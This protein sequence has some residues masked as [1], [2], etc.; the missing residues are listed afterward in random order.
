MMRPADKNKSP[1]FPANMT[2]IGKAWRQSVVYA[3]GTFL[4]GVGQIALAPLLTR[5]LSVAE[6]GSYEVLLVTYFVLKTLLVIPLSSALVY[7]QC[8]CCGTPEERKDLLSTVSLISAM[9]AA[10]F[11]LCGILA[12]RW[13]SL[14]V[15][16]GSAASA[17]GAII[18]L[19][20]ALDVFVQL[21]LGAFRAAEQPFHYGVAALIQLTGTLL[22]S[23]AFVGRFS[24]G[25]RGVF[26]AMAASNLFADIFI[27]VALALG[28]R[29]S[30]RLDW[31]R[32][33]PVL[34]FAL[35]LVPMHA[36]NLVSSVS[37]RYFLRSY[38]DLRTVGVYALSYRIG[39]GISTLVVL[40]FLTAW[41]ALI[42]AEKD[43][44][45]IGGYVGKAASNLWMAGM[46]FVAVG[47]AAARP[48]LLF[49]GGGK[50]KFLPAA[51]IVPIV[52]LGALL[53]GVMQ[54]FLSLAVARGRI[55]L[56]MKVLVAAAAAALVFNALLIPAYGMYGAALATVLSYGTGAALAY[57]NVSRLGPARLFFETRKAL[58]SLACGLLGAAAGRSIDGVSASRPLNFLLVVLLSSAVYISAVKMT[59]LMPAAPFGSRR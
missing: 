49:L 17:S 15:G 23:G 36:A 8:K 7:G 58:A 26:D 22:L 42:Y 21:G 29:F 2:I 34:V 45:A 35:T 32:A 50:L 12:P 6:Y 24:M 54:V 46:F 40:P 31:A 9:L 16:A 44:A 57:I 20:L 38:W 4:L 59:G 43:P 55:Y 3:A 18:F 56:N 25:A 47:A 52:S 41:P 5:N 10:A 11:M 1:R 53:Y 30:F 51:E 13:P 14:L 27:F 33:K 39:S 48:L 19:A 37:D 28:D